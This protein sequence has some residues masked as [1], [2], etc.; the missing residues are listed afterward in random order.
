MF[1]DAISSIEAQHLSD[2]FDERNW[3]IHSGHRNEIFDYV[4]G[5]VNASGLVNLMY[6][7]LGEVSYRYKTDVSSRSMKINI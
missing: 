7:D 6:S 4:I 5:R 2:R 1:K 3:R